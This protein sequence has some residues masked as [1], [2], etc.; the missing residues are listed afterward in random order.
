MLQC[1]LMELYHSRTRAGGGSRGTAK[2][3]GQTALF[4]AHCEEKSLRAPG[5][6][7]PM[8]ARFVQLQMSSGLTGTAPETGV[9]CGCVD[10]GRRG[11]KAG[12][13][14]TCWDQLPLGRMR[15]GRGAEWASC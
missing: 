8:Q 4:L 7:F 14:R 12:E 15:K 2:R 6:H 3:S 9:A 10:K 5:D 13:G 1:A 11:C